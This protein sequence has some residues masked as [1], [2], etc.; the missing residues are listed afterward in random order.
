MVYIERGR[1][2]SRRNLEEFLA[3]LLSVQ[4]EVDSK[5]AT[6]AAR[7]EGLLAEHRAQ[8]VARIELAKGDVDAYVVLVDANATNKGSSSNSA[9]SIERGRAG[10][11]DKAGNVVG[12]MDGLFILA[13]AARLPRTRRGG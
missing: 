8:G 10:H 11:V 5:A 9:L 1:V 3:H 7:A 4:H 12:G 6:I 13:Q 2:G